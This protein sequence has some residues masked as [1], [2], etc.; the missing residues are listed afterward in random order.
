[1]HCLSKELDEDTNS[2]RLVL[3]PPKEVGLPLAKEKGRQ[4]VYRVNTAHQLT[5]RI[6]SR[7]R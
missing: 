7:I 5:N 1:M 2:V 6:V 3:N 4:K